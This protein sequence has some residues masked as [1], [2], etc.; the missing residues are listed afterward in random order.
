[1][2]RHA[3]RLW[4][5]LA[6]G[7]A[8]LTTSA[9][10]KSGTPGE[11]P[12]QRWGG[13]FL[14]AP[15]DKDLPWYRRLYHM[16]DWPES[17]SFPQVTQNRYQPYDH[18]KVLRAVLRDGVLEPQWEAKTIRA[19]DWIP[20]AAEVRR[21]GKVDAYVYRQ[22]WRGGVL[23]V[24]D[25]RPSL[26]VA[27]RSE[28]RKLPSA[29][30]LAAELFTLTLPADFP[31][32]RDESTGLDIGPVFL[33][34]PGDGWERAERGPHAGDGARTGVGFIMLFCVSRDD[35][36]L[37]EFQK[38]FLEGASLNPGLPLFRLSSEKPN[39]IEQA[40]DDFARMD[41][42]TGTNITEIARIM[43]SLPPL[44]PD[45]WRVPAHM[46]E[47]LLRAKYEGC[48]KIK[49]VLESL[50]PGE[51]NIPVLREVMR[52]FPTEETFRNPAAELERCAVRWLRGING[53]L[54]LDELRRIARSTKSEKTAAD[55]LEIYLES[56]PVEKVREYSLGQLKEL[57]LPPICFPSRRLCSSRD[58]ERSP[59]PGTRICCGEF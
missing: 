36:I 4:L 3:I 21:N 25:T 53:Q 14:P 13:A 30:A 19:K 34:P 12:P 18:E 58:W 40:I 42:V 7:L 44:A 6:V 48:E 32:K 45:R 47:L 51:E 49:A 28:G 56:L 22:K 24:C 9:S 37:F 1:M 31:L 50:P 33:Q 8:V 2:K 10:D 39:T 15:R 59:I 57:A 11:L 54:A 55:C 29:S 43:A 41:R 52:V 26:L 20:E 5:G 38:S 16:T 35:L 23:H 17:N 46:N 27:L